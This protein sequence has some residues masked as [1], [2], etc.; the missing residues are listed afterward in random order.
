MT[1]KMLK[2]HYDRIDRSVSVVSREEYG[3]VPKKA[4]VLGSSLM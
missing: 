1:F 2:L 3:M 4:N